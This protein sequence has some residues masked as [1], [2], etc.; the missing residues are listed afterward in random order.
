MSVLIWIQTIWHSYSVDELR[1]VRRQQ[2]MHEKLL[3]MGEIFMDY[4]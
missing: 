4:S 3:S 2:Q 1:N